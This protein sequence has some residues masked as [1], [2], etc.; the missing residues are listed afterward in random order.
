MKEL[1]KMSRE[2]AEHMTDLANKLLV[3][4]EETGYSYHDVMRALDSIKNNYKKK[5]R[6]FLN[7]INIQKV[8]EFGSL[9]D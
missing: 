9:L 7:S 5:G 1:E 2:E 8:A 4:I 6:D 3:L